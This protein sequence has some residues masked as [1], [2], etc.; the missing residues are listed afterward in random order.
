MYVM[1]NVHNKCKILK[2]L[3]ER[4]DVLQSLKDWTAD[5]T[6]YEMKIKKGQRHLPKT[7]KTTK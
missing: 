4:K 2:Q 1:Y 7:H 3:L 6:V 5:G